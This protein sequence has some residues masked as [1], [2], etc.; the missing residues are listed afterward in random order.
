[1]ATGWGWGSIGGWRWDAEARSGAAAAL[2]STR[3]GVP[4]ATSSELGA[5]A[6]LVG[7]R[8]RGG[9]G[10]VA[11]HT[12]AAEGTG[13]HVWTE[14]G[15]AR[16]GGRATEGIA[17]LLDTVRRPDVPLTTLR[18]VDVRARRPGGGQSAEAK[19]AQQQ[20]QQQQQHRANDRIFSTSLRDYVEGA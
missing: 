15:V 4:E 1:V 16:G 20:Q 12:G 8:R 10:S 18:L 6:V 2:T 14:H 19:A 17:A 11:A 3:R 9:A 13:E 5:A 7:A